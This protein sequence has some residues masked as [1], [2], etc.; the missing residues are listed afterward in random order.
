MPSKWPRQTGIQEDSISEGFR[1]IIGNHENVKMPNSDAAFWSNRDRART[2]RFLA[3]ILIGLPVF[4]ALAQQTQPASQSPKISVDVNLVL[5]SATVRDKHGN[6]VPA[7]SR[8]DF[9]LYADGHVQAINNFMRQSDLPL[10]LG[11]L[12]QTS[13]GPRQRYALHNAGDS[14][15]AF[16]DHMLREE[17]DK[18]FVVRFDQKVELLQDFSSSRP[19]LRAAL[20]METTGFSSGGPGGAT[21]LYD[22]VCLASSELKAQQGRKA[23]FVLSDGIDRGSKKTLEDAVEAAQ[24][25]DTSVYS[26][27]LTENW[28][29]P[30]GKKVLERIST[31]TGGRMFKI[32][33]GLTVAQIYAQ[34]EEELRNEYVLSYTPAAL[35]TGGGYHK[36]QLTTKQK[37]LTVQARDGYYSDQ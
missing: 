18:A 25:A 3:P 26:I 28:P 14:S 6:I 12:V 7:L 2:C 30:S 35:G 33:H 17:K 10:T 36:I 9:V 13:L 19:K 4:V 31:E 23:L 16:L 34:A 37:G 27:L 22:A 1:S 8:D 32:S 11:L 24:R 21:L 15:Y 29:G 5:I 20:D